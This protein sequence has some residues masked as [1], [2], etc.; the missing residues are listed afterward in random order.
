MQNG[1]VQVGGDIGAGGFCSA[2]LTRHI[3]FFNDPGGSGPHSNEGK[4]KD[5]ET[6]ND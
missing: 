6:N 1:V 4:Q 5:R 3:E 2:L